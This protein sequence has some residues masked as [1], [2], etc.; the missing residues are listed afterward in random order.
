MITRPIRPVRE[1]PDP[2]TCQA[3]RVAAGWS[4]RQLADQLGC[5]E[6]SVIRWESGTRVVSG[7]FY[8][9]YSA[10]LARLDTKDRPRDP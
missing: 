4:R 7:R 2:A 3:I 6:Q 10:L 8:A 9:A 5:H 1:L